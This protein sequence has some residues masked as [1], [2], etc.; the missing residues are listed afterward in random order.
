MD[1]VSYLFNSKHCLIKPVLDLTQY[2]LQFQFD[3]ARFLYLTMV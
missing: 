1:K 2:D 3:F